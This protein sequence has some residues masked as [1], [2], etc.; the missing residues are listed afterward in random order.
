MTSHTGMLAD[1]LCMINT[2]EARVDLPSEELLVKEGKIQESEKKG[3][4]I[5]P[6]NYDWL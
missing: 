4:L 1:T 3:M 2:D 6:Y 5:V